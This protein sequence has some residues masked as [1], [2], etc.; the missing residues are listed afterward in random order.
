MSRSWPYAESVGDVGESIRFP[1]V[2]TMV[3][4]VALARLPVKLP[5][6]AASRA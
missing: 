6:L 1:T 5:A 2:P 4:R 3:I